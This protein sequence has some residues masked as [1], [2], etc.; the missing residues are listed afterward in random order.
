MYLFF[1]FR[2]GDGKGFTVV[3]GVPKVGQ[4]QNAAWNITDVCRFKLLPLT[5]ANVT[6][7]DSKCRAD[8]SST[9]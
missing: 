8:P 4:L 2:C 6:S 7:S 9:G 3:G 5:S 1:F